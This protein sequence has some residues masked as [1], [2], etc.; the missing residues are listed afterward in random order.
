MNE[1]RE[2]VENNVIEVV[3]VFHSH[4]CGKWLQ[5][6]KISLKYTLVELL[7]DLSTRPRND[8]EQLANRLWVNT[9]Y[10]DTRLLGTGH[11]GTTIW[12]P[13]FGHQDILVPFD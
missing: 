8:L 1:V 12:T 9:V 13:P 7:P 4:M 2:V 5:T 3:V 10:K 11:F 6:M